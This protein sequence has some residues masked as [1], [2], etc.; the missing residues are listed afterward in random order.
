MGGGGGRGMGGGGGA[1]GGRGMG[2][3]GGA[4]GG[5]GRMEGP[6][7]GL[8]ASGSC[9]CPKCGYRQPHRPGVPCM[10]ERCPS[11]N[12]ALLREGSPHHEQ[13]MEKKGASSEDE[14]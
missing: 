9:V 3:G 8:G 13:V 4:G 2:G 12:C 1:G 10:E 7:G 6:G 5:R 14:E 11:C